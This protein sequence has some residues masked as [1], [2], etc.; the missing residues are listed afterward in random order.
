MSNNINDNKK[1]F[2]KNLKNKLMEINDEYNYNIEW[3][4]DIEKKKTKND[5]TIDINSKEIHIVLTPEPSRS[6]GDGDSVQNL[7]I[8][9]LVN[10]VDI[11]ATID[12]LSRYQDAAVNKKWWTEYGILVNESWMSPTLQEN[13]IDLR[14]GKGAVISMIGSASFTEGVVDIEK[15]FIFEEHNKLFEFLKS[16]SADT[17][18]NSTESNPRKKGKNRSLLFKIDLKCKNSNSKFCLT[19]RQW[20]EG[21]ISQ[22]TTI[23]V[24]LKYTDGHEK[25]YYMIIS[26]VVFTTTDGTIPTLSVSLM[27]KM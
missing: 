18:P 15:V 9:A 2:E 7:S 23:P 13:F 22:N 5:P 16:T 8:A 3:Y 20:E 6:Y 25:T 24:K 11:A 4:A 1:A 17:I 26:S 14:V 12:I 27:E 10:Q 21:E 19:C